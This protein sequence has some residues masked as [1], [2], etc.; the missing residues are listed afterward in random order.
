MPIET[1]NVPGEPFAVQRV[2][3]SLIV[4]EVID[5][6]KTLYLDPDHDARRPV[7]WDTR[8][9]NVKSGFSEILAMVEKST[10]LWSKMAGGRSAILVGQKKNAATARLY[11]SLAQ[12]MPREL[13]IF[14]SY[15]DAVAWLRFG[16]V[17]QT[18]KA[19]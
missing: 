18:P 3:N 19:S 10:S 9:V 5:A 12:A 2:T 11:A 8:L 17:G 4:S 16:D 6:Q 1:I 14:T 15:E 13:S 7:L